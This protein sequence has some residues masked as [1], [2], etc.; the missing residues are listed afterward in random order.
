VYVWHCDRETRYSMYSGG[1]TDQDYLRGV[2]IADATGTVRFT[3]I[4][5]GCYAGRWPHV[6]FEVYPEQSAI[7][8]AATA[9]ATSQVALPEA[10]WSVPAMVRE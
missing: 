8:D 6:H 2:Q 1:V 3:S 7:T 5:P 10:A 9:I 4:F